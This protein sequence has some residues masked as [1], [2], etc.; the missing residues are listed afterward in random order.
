[1]HFLVDITIR[2]R[3]PKKELKS[4]DVSI[5]GEKVELQWESDEVNV[6]KTTLSPPR[7]AHLLNT[8]WFMM[9]SM[10]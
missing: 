2:L 8:A 10:V 4:I 1:M 5:G 7:Y 3:D 9:K 6:R